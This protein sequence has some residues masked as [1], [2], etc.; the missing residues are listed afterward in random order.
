MD[1]NVMERM[2]LKRQ[3]RK[4]R[5]KEKKAAKERERERASE[6]AV[7]FSE[8][9]RRVRVVWSGL[10]NG[11]LKK[12]K[13]HAFG[14]LNQ[15]TYE[16]WEQFG[17]DLANCHKLEAISFNDGIVGSEIND[18]QMMSSLF[19]GWARRSPIKEIMFTSNQFSVAGIR[20]MVPF[21]QNANNLQFLIMHRTNQIQSE[22][23]NLLLRALHDSPIERLRVSRCSIG[24]ITIDI[25]HSPR[26]LKLLNLCDNNINSD[27][28]RE[29]AK[30]LQGR[31]ATLESL[32]LD[33]NQIDD[34][35]VG[36][37]VSALHNNK[38]LKTLFL[39]GNNAISKRGK[40]K[41]L[42]LVNDI[43][44]IEATIR[45]NQTL[46]GL[47]IDENNMSEIQ[48]LINFAC[49]CTSK[50]Q[51]VIATQLHSTT[52][53]NFSRLQGIERSNDAFYGEFD[54]LHLPEILALVGQAH[55]LSELHVALKSSMAALLSTVDRIGCLEQELAYHQSR[56]ADIQAEIASI[57]RAEGHRDYKRQRI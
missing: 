22:G 48:E 19:R 43:S 56:V 47:Y 33:N 24:S 13:T 5:R 32:Y 29:L 49:Q 40:I 42:K 31:D 3:Q 4:A 44:S 39:R 45:S 51:K 36:I 37:L 2:R 28:C 9:Y 18:D 35:G 14:P 57:K 41:L 38:S 20:S 7:H 25:E 10:T 46:I 55:G 6:T 23:F 17:R 54:P 26:H 21:L 53:S 50:R 8:A 30:L 15:L 16:D 12:F 34:N 1:S 27:G 52:R 11:T